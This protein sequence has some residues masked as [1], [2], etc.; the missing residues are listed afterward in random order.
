[1]KLAFLGTGA[2]FS[3]ER[4]N[5]AVVVNDHILLDAGAPLLPHMH[6][7]GIDPA[8]IDLLFV[9]HFHGDH[10]LGLAS[11]LLHRA[12][13]APAPLVVVGPQDTP[14]RLEELGQLAWRADW[15]EIR[16]RLSIEHQPASAEG[17]AAGV[18]FE[19]RR[20]VHGT[21]GGTGYRIHIDGRTLVYA[22]DTEPTPELDELVRGADV[23]IT[24]ATGPGSVPSHT[25][26]EEAL[27]LRDRHPGTRFIFTHVFAGELEGAASDLTVVEV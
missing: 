13:V 7:L 27:A 18:D 23:A 24:E 25:P 26:W 3:S 22:G 10:V 8:A 5:C 2:A 4:Y 21:E 6:R 20:L 12:F 14:Q 1:M 16:S 11:F 19:S 17:K 9:S 15:P